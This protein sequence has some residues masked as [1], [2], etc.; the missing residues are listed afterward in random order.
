MTRRPKVLCLRPLADFEAVGVAVPEGVDVLYTAGEVPERL[1]EDV[2]CVVLPSAGPPLAAASFSD[3]TA[4][5]LLQYTGAGTDRVTPEVVSRLGCAV[6]NVPGAS[7]PDVAAYVVVT[8]GVLTRRLLAGDHFV[9]SGSF[10]AGRA[11][12]N[13]GKA[14]GF[15]G[16]RAGVLGCG[17]IGTEVARLFHAMGA[18]VSWFDKQPRSGLPFASAQ[19]DLDSLAASSDVLSIHVPLDASTTG[20]VGAPELAA[21]PQGAIVV[22][23]ARGGVLDEAAAIA[24]LDRGHL[25]GLVLDV[26]EREPLEAG[27]PVLAAANRHPYD[28]VLTPHIAGVTLEA[29]QLLFSRAWANVEGVLVHGREPHDRVR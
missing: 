10:D 11:E 20:L 4:L 7:A 28:V 17:A 14:R 6:C 5:R 2:S 3:L 21:L 12:L 29:S 1:A 8:T 23:A 16:L 24:A 15:R 25:G 22:N 18:S 13:A 27:S 9:R 19:P 26:F